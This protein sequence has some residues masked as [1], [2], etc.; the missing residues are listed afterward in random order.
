MTG[1]T[2][3][4]N[5][6]IENL[7]IIKYIKEVIVSRHTRHLSENMV[8]HNFKNPEE[9]AALERNA[10][11][12]QLDFNEFPAAEYRYFDRIQ[13]IGYRSRHEGLTREQARSERDKALK[14]YRD[15][16][17]ALTG[18]LNAARQYTESRVRMGAL[19]DEIYKE[20]SP[21]RKLRLALEFVELTLHEEGFAR[22]NLSGTY[23]EVEKNA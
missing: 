5:P 14:D 16:I 2:G 3:L 22:R 7:K 12:G 23:L 6:F 4:Y 18:N 8:K 1:V 19:V 11:D 13:D 10:Y 15:D 9:F 20:H 17:D 21:Q